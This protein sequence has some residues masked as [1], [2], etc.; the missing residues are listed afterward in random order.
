MAKM[1]LE[2]Q[3]DRALR[4]LAAQTK[5]VRYIVRPPR[6]RGGKKRA[7]A[8]PDFYDRAHAADGRVRVTSPAGVVIGTYR[9]QAAALRAARRHQAHGGP[10]RPDRDAPCVR[11]GAP[12]YPQADGRY[13]GV[14][15]QLV[16]V[17]PGALRVP[18]GGKG[19]RARAAK[20]WAR[21][22]K[23]GAF[24]R[25]YLVTRPRDPYTNKVLWEVEAP[26][27]EVVVDGEETRRA[28][29]AHARAHAAA[30]FPPGPRRVRKLHPT[31][32][33]YS[34]RARRMTMARGGKVRKPSAKLIT[35]ED[36]GFGPWSAFDRRRARHYGVQLRLQAKPYARRIVV[37]T[38]DRLVRWVIGTADDAAWSPRITKQQALADIKRDEVRS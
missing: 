38:R 27:G 16:A 11:C 14:C 21:H 8:W 9:T 4:V 34:K 5:P 13:C 35:I 1:P 18:R 24:P 36:R 12:T 29:L 37:G 28:A 22:R 25:G 3:I 6:P 33:G 32:K 10:L 19:R 31:L 15:R 23:L 7:S 20:P 2:S 17:R 30:N 26:N